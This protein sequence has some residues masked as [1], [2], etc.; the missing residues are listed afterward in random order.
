M[1]PVECL[2]FH[3]TVMSVHLSVCLDQTRNTGHSEEEIDTRADVPLAVMKYFGQIL[4]GVLPRIK[5][6]HIHSKERDN[7][8]IS[9]GH[10]HQKH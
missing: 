4:A 2:L 10:G 5:Q 6:N 8:G 7:K 3:S 1:L 9:I